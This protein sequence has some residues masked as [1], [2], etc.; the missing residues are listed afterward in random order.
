LEDEW[1]KRIKLSTIYQ[2][3]THE[4]DK[5]K[6]ELCSA[7]NTANRP[8]DTAIQKYESPKKENLLIKSYACWVL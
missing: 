1:S 4:M 5:Y 8:V 3:K 6:A 7:F 2:V